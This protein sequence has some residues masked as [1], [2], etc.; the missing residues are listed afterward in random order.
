MIPHFM[1]DSI[2]D[3]DSMEQCA[4]HTLT[5]MRMHVVDGVCSAGAWAVCLR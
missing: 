5:K 4:K 3:C 1:N 2:E